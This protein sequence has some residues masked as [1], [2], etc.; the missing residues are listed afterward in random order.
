MADIDYLAAYEGVS[1][2]SDFI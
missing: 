1:H 2:L